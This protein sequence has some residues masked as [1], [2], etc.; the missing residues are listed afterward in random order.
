MEHITIRNFGP[1]RKVDIDL[2]KNME[3]VIGPQASG[4]STFSKT[5]YFCK[6]I[7]DYFLQ[8]LNGIMNTEDLY[9]EDLYFN[10]LKFVRRPFMG[11]FGTTKH[12]DRFEIMYFYHKEKNRFVKIILDDDRFAKFSFS[13]EMRDELCDM[14]EQA[15]KVA[16]ESRK[17][18]F[19]DSY[20]AQ[21][22]FLERLRVPVN[23]IFCDDSMLMY[24]PAGR[25]LLAV[26][27]DT[28]VK[29]ETSI[30][31]DEEMSIDISQ[32]DLITQEFIRY[33]RKIRSE[34]GT[35]LEE[36]TQNYLKTVRGEIRNHDVELACGLIRKILRAD[37]ICDREG[38]KL[39]YDQEHWVKLMFG[40][41]GQQEILWA[42]NII[43]MAILKN[44]KTFLVFEEPE[45]HL[46]PDAQETIAQ[47]AALLI[48]SSKSR[49]IVTTHSPYMLTAANL[50]IYS[51]VEEGKSG[52]NTVVKK[53]LRLSPG[54]V[55]AYF[56][57]PDTRD[58]KSIIGEGKGLIDALQIDGIS[59]SINDRMDQIM[60]NSFRNRGKR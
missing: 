38:E 11:Y 25:N 56:L 51:G 12:M 29:G 19:A 16:K 36:I 13:N 59:A 52:E 6:K 49:I 37:Y 8:Y 44:E 43:F 5:I 20:L 50:L 46:F 14:I 60:E 27:P 48:N 33:I 15:V 45:S 34:F 31:D 7:R 9:R 23:E 47:L 26:V 22:G 53:E 21:A 17:L 55:G 41:S 32:I 4:K 42:L 35:K 24:I 54:T 57:S 10:F 39:F 30:Q 3:V 40:S 28:F 58:M 18:S 2:N 1:V